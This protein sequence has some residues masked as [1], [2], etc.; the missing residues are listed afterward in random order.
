MAFNI[1]NLVG[2][3]NVG[4]TDQ[5]L[6]L[7]YSTGDNIADIEAA[8]YFN[9]GIDKLRLGDVVRVTANDG[10]GLYVVDNAS[11][12]SGDVSITKLAVASSFPGL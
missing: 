11:H 2:K 12:S 3:R 8:S 7:D 5:T 9:S 4:P 6:V 10:K 1:T